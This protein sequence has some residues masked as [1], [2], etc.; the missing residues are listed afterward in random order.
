M[1]MLYSKR[2]KNFLGGGRKKSN[3][4][5]SQRYSKKGRHMRGGSIDTV[6]NINLE[7][8]GFT[9]YQ[10]NYQPC[11]HLIGERGDET[12]KKI[13]IQCLKETPEW[14][15][16]DSNAKKDEIKL[17]WN[18]LPEISRNCLIK[19]SSIEERDFINKFVNLND[20][21]AVNKW[22][23]LFPEKKKFLIGILEDAKTKKEFRETELIQEWQTNPRTY[24][25]YNSEKRNADISRIDAERKYNAAKQQY[26]LDNEGYNARKEQKSKVDKIPYILGFSGTKYEQYKQYKEKAELSKTNMDAAEQEWGRLKAKYDTFDDTYRLPATNAVDATLR[27][28]IDS[29]KYIENAITE[30]NFLLQN[31]LGEEYLN[32]PSLWLEKNPEQKNQII[33]GNY[34]S[35]KGVDT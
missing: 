23:S 18:A 31:K 27:S 11:K 29:E 2:R 20:T 24:P 32:E 6:A 10:Y 26:N 33:N 8:Y 22:E 13:Y 7:N 9:G 35:K 4:S 28:T 21:S 34:Y 16:L 19:A 15:N 14:D 17:Q 12:Q 1:A 3:R 30:I 5:S 25:R